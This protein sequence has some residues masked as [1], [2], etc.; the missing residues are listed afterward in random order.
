MGDAQLTFG[1]DLVMP[2]ATARGFLPKLPAN[3]DVSAELGNV[4]NGVKHAAGMSEL[5]PHSAAG[6]VP[7]SGVE[8]V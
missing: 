3:P 5:Q 6:D 2:I 8:S 7:T 1:E 4:V